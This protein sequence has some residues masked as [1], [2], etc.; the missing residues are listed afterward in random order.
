MPYGG[1]GYSTR[2][3][4]YRGNGKVV[5]SSLTGAVK[6]AAEHFRKSYRYNQKG[7]QFNVVYRFLTSVQLKRNVLLGTLYY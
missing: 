4:A 7:Y 5:S 1:V 6:F 3:L 2:M